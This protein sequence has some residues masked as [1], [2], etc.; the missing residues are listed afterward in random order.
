M[1]L[2]NYMDISFGLGIIVG[3]LTATSGILLGIS[4]MKY[5]ECRQMLANHYEIAGSS[6]LRTFICNDSSLYEKGFD[7]AQALDNYKTI[8]D[9]LK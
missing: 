7:R 8:V 9:S 6:E 4:Y 3:V 2:K 1:E 5:N